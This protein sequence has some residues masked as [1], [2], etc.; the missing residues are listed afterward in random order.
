MTV[1]FNVI[2][3]LIDFE[4]LVLISL[5][6]LFQVSIFIRAIIRLFPQ[7]C[8]HQKQGS[9]YGKIFVYQ[10]NFLIFGFFFSKLTY[11]NQSFSYLLE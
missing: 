9:F 6:F 7:Q 8:N 10:I 4:V 2:F 11:S 3:Y 1:G 5:F